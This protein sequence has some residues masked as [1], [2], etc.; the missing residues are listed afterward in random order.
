MGYLRG[1]AEFNRFLCEQSHGPALP[2]CRRFRTGQCDEP[3][4]KD[5]VKDHFTRWFVL[6]FALKRRIQA[7]FYE[8]LFQVLDRSRRYPHR[9]GR[10]RHGPRR[11]LRACIAQE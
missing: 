8:A 3:R 2:P 1:K 10:I 7:F 9:L 11:P 6:L 5:P 4:L